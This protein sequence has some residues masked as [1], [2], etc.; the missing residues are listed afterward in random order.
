[1]ARPESRFGG[2]AEV[3]FAE[4]ARGGGGVLLDHV[5]KLESDRG[6]LFEPLASRGPD[7]IFS[8]PWK[9]VG[10]AFLPEI[11]EDLP[12]TIQKKIQIG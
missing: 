9:I 1:L 3:N 10:K 2:A 6:G 4:A 7:G 12:E 11:A 8:A 5:E